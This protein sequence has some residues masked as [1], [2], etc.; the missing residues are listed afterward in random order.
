MS[1][2]L[3]SRTVSLIFLAASLAGS[4]SIASEKDEAFKIINE[5][6]ATARTGQYPEALDKLEEAISF[7][8]FGEQ[9][10]A[11][12]IAHNNMAEI[13]LLQRNTLQALSHHY[14]ALR[15][16]NEIGH[17]NGIVATG[18]QIDEILAQPKTGSE[19]ST[20]GSTRPLVSEISAETRQRLLNEAMKRVRNR[21]KT[22]QAETEGGKTVPSQASRETP[23]PPQDP[24]LPQI[25]KTESAQ[26]VKQA[27]YNTYL[28]R[29]KKSVFRA[30]EPEQAS[31]NKEQGR[32][33]LEFTILRD[34]SLENIRILRSSGYPSLDREAMRAVK[35]V[36]P[37]RPLPERTGLSELSIRY[38]FNYSLK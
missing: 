3:F 31:R 9:K 37:F 34:G 38:T 5:A 26:D 29:V 13:Y 27:E 6:R 2:T 14:Q 4:Y 8:D 15:I 21:I 30:W 12:A 32:V 7:A 17:R 11:M 18:R 19:K 28:E 25:A 16:Y 1:R 33:V 10:L 24:L 23:A 22:Q 36:S 35:A 20:P